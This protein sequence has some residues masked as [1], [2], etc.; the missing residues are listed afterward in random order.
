MLQHTYHA[1]KDSRGLAVHGLSGARFV[2]KLKGPE[3][4]P[5]EGD[6]SI[7]EEVDRIFLHDGATPI[8][9]RGASVDGKTVEVEYG[10]SVDG[11]LE[12]SQCEVVVWNPWADKS[13]K[14]ADFPDEGYVSMLCIEPGGV[15]G[16]ESLPAGSAYS[17][18]QRV[19]FREP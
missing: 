3:L 8:T 7:C 19:A 16:K 5:L 4:H 9:V 14:L 10:A 13:A 12:P 1:V 11:S 2:D 18:F 17:V 15:Y 6:V